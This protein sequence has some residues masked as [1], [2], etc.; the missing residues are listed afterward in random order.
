MSATAYVERA[1]IVVPVGSEDDAHLCTKSIDRA[2][3]ELTFH[4]GLSPDGLPPA[5]H[6]WTSWA[7][8]SDEKASIESLLP[9]LKGA[10]V[11]DGFKVTPAEVLKELGLERLTPRALAQSAKDAPKTADEVAAAEEV[12]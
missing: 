6:L 4:A 1:V 2:G 8:T 3:G 12:R 11:F 5:T 9:F 7:M 10:Q